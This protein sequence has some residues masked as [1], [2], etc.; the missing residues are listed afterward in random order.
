MDDMMLVCKRTYSWVVAATLTAA[1]A[2]A[3]GCN[4]IQPARPAHLDIW[5][6]ASAPDRFC[7]WLG[8][9]SGQLLAASGAPD[10][11]LQQWYGNRLS[12]AGMTD[13][14]CE[15]ST[16][17]EAAAV[18]WQMM[19]DEWMMHQP[20]LVQCIEYYSCRVLDWPMI[21]ADLIALLRQPSK[22]AVCVFC[23]SV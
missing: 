15:A 22:C 13:T 1:A 4:A 6:G 16:V 23:V 17:T 9:Q 8:Y 5:A 2:A 19:A 3:I 18:E 21:A 10:Q 7:C 12:F 20:G 11:V 14:C